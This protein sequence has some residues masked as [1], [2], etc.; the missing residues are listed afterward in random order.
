MRLPRACL[1]V[2]AF[3]S[4]ALMVY[5][6]KSLDNT[7]I[8][9]FGQGKQCPYDFLKAVLQQVATWFAT[10]GVKVNTGKTHDIF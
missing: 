8:L 3:F 4:C 7:T 6:H 9:S 10:N 2:L 1:L 5:P